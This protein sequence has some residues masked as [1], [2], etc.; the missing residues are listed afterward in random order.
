MFQG[1]Q[2]PRRLWVGFQSN[3][4]V[5]STTSSGGGTLTCAKEEMASGS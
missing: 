5:S 2:Q 1:G 3:R 4:G